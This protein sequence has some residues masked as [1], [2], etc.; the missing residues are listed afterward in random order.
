MAKF[1]N[2]TIKNVKTKQKFIVR[3]KK[4]SYNCIGEKNETY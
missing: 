3:N 4:F 1:T 2:E